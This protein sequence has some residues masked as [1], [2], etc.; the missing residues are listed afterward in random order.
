MK[1]A[2]FLS[3]LAHA[4]LLVV[5]TFWPAPRPKPRAAL[6]VIPLVNIP[7]PAPILPEPDV[8]PNPEDRK[9]DPEALAISSRPPTPLTPPTATPTVTRTKP[10]MST[11]SPTQTARPSDTATS[12][13]TPTKGKR[14]L[15]Q[16][17]NT[18]AESPTKKEDTAT[19]A[20]TRDRRT[21]LVPT[22]DTRL[23]RITPARTRQT[24]RVPDVDTSVATTSSGSSR[25]GPSGGGYSSGGSVV[26]ATDLPFS[27]YD[28]YLAA[29]ERQCYTIWER[30]K[31]RKPPD[32]RGTLQAEVTF[33]ISADGRI[34]NA[35]LTRSSGDG[36]FDQE[37]TVA[38]SEINA[39]VLP[40]VFG[41]RSIT[42]AATF[43]T[44]Y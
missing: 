21:L 6:N 18:P 40:E 8:V 1:L 32:F 24:V 41:G 7:P 30:R 16:P 39:G 22:P 43:R 2:I 17:T 27:D 10:P 44:T 33:E 12:T 4:L 23:P 20:P 25:P 38:V 11:E 5:L 9:R 34:S 29:L 15:K 14:Q 36:P 35:R 28:Y 31:P 13:A 19:P 37:A 42:V 26:I 3:A